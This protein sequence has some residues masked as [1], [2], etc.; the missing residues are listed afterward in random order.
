MRRKWFAPADDGETYS[1][2]GIDCEGAATLFGHRSGWNRI[3]AT[4][5]TEP[6]EQTVQEVAETNRAFWALLDQQPPPQ[7]LWRLELRP[8][9]G[10]L[11]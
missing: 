9:K 6:D 10:R 8:R 5:P 3:H 4:E 1:P 11:A 7:R 2:F